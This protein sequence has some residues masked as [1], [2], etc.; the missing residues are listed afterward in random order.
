MIRLKGRDMPDVSLAPGL[1]VFQAVGIDT[2]D[3]CSKGH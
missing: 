3:I 1:E 2:R